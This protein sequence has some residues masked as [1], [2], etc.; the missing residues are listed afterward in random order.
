MKAEFQSLF[1]AI[2]E[3]RRP[4]PRE[5]TA[6]V[7]ALPAVDRLPSPWEAWALIGLVRHRR[8]Q[9]W[10]GDVITAR[11]GGDLLELA[12]MGALGHP[13]IPQSGPVPGLPE[14]GYYFHG[15]GC[16]LT[17]RVRGEEIDVDLF[18]DSAEYID[19]WFYQNHLKSLRDPQPPER[20]LLD[21]HPSVEPIRLAAEGLLSA[22]LLA[23]LPGRDAFP[24][25]VADSALCYEQEVT[26]FCQS[27]CH[28]GRRL[29]LAALVG[30]WPTAHDEAVR[31]GDPGLVEVT[32]GR[33]PSGPGHRAHLSRAGRHPA[34]G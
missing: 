30:D 29:W 26:D 4:G 17:H 21:L 24:F 13:P 20:R 25:R 27:W 33:G 3:A 8:R 14:W 11:L 9:L 2:G 18:D 16:C 10:V 1:Q 34:I 15:K 22:G 7:Q 12:R 19:L 32:T 31:R 23:P 6:A 28:E 5:L